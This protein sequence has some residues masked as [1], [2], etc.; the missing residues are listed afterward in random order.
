MARH[1][2]NLGHQPLKTCPNCLRSGKG[3]PFYKWSKLPM[4]GQRKEICQKNTFP[5]ADDRFLSAR[6][7]IFWPIKD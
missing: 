2:V 6:A 5:K 1:P 4:N 3:M 7:A